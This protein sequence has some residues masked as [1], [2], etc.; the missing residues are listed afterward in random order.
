MYAVRML[1]LRVRGVAT[2]RERFTGVLMQHSAAEWY[3]LCKVCLTADGGPLLASAT[4]TFVVRMRPGA[5]VIGSNG[6]S[7]TV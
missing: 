1:G 4:G 3:S 5:K 2:D 6:Y 7:E